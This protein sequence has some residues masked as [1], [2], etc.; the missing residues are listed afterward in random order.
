MP[1]PRAL[2][3]PSAEPLA[4]VGSLAPVKPLA[5]VE[6]LAPA[7]EAVLAAH[8]VEIYRYLRRLVPSAE[9]AADLHQETFVR[10]FR[11]YP[12]LDAAANVR[13]WLYRIAGNLARDA[14]RRRT[15]R[16]AMASP[17]GGIASNAPA[18]PADDPAAHALAGE[19]AD[20]IREALLGLTSR[21]RAAVI[22]R[23]LEG[24]EYADVARA[25]G[26][27]ETTARQ[28]VS[29]GLRRLRGRLA[30]YVEMDR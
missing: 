20:V 12:R 27:S 4:P 8:E 9:E 2:P 25:L 5:P 15:V 18:R 29:Q 28:H 19:M 14:Y 6:P 26:C 17:L 21:Q 30:A 3:S 10:A 24:G 1:A 13:A 22:G 23:V 16:S 7:F 11:A